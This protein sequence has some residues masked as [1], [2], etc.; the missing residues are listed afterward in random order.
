MGLMSGTSLD[1]V[2]G[3]VLSGS[4]HSGHRVTASVH[5]DM[6]AP[7][8]TALMALQHSGPDEL[9]RSH[10]A[11]NALAQ[12]YAQVVHRLLA[13]S[14]LSARDIRAI[15]AHGQTVRHQP[16]APTQPATT[17]QPDPAQPWLAYTV[18]LNNPALLAELTGIT[19]VADF[20]SRDVAA[21]GQGA[22]L[23]PAFHQALFGGPHAVAVVNIG[24]MANVTVLHPGHP[25]T[26]FDT[27]PGN[28]LM[29]LWCE[30]HQGTHFDAGGAWAASGRC[31]DSLLQQMLAEPFFSLHGP[32][33]TGRDHFNAAWLDQHLRQHLNQHPALAPEDV[34]A[35]LLQLTAR[36]I[37]HAIPANTR[38]MVVCGGGG[39]NQRLLAA[40]SEALPGTQVI[41]SDRLGV[42]LMDVEAAAFAWL[43]QR[44]LDGLPGNVVQVTGAAGPRVLGAIYPA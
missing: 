40:L 44:T 3:V 29:D 41:P 28:V 34:Q 21:G 2:D 9:H 12:A 42:P 35:T 25:V 33:S 32:R 37:A 8:R 18:Q 43:A 10:W 36:S 31:V 13:S 30:R 5:L 6:P 23:V 22:P 1:G 20:R 11:A 26:G 16:A 7:L 38:Q 19:V 4:A 39:L 27:G 15:G 24:G 14:G 17:P